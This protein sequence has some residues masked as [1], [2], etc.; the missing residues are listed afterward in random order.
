MIAGNPKSAR[1]TALLAI[2]VI[3]FVIAAFAYLFVF[4]NTPPSKQEPLHP[5]LLVVQ[6]KSLH[7]TCVANPHSS[8]AQGGPSGAQLGRIRKVA[9]LP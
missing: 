1:P 2:A 7:V 6:T 3:L 5:A 9:L 8:R 4:K